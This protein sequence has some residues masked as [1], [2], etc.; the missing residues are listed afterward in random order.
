MNVRGDPIPND[1]IP[2]ESKYRT[3]TRGGTFH[4]TGART[5]AASSRKGTGK[6]TTGYNREINVLVNVARGNR[7]VDRQRTRLS[8][9][10][11]S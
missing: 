8:S 3:D 5:I 10:Y 6:T 4:L 2:D 7:N 11:R 1:I 9:I